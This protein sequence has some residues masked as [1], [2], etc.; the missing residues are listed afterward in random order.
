VS[1]FGT[2]TAKQA[3]ASKK[4]A[5]RALAAQKAAKKKAAAT[6]AKRAAA[7]KAPA[8][9]P[10]GGLVCQGSGGPGASEQ[11]ITAIGKAINAYRKSHGLRSLTIARSS[12]LVTHA[13]RMATTGGIWHSGHENIVAC[14]SNDSATTMVKAWA[15]SAPHRKQMLRTGVKHMSVGGAVNDGWLFGAVL[16]S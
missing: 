10:A 2:Q 11:K 9:V 6:T 5:A 4:A 14:V 16:F 3:A 15:N 12:T 13:K 1:I 7:I 8:H